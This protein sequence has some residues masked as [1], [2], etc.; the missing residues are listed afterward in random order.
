MSSKIN[1]FIGRNFDTEKFSGMIDRGELQRINVQFKVDAT[2][3]I[4]DIKAR[5]QFKPLEKEA[6]RVLKKLP[7]ITPGK[8]G[9]R[10]VAVIY[11]VPI[12]FKMGY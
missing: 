3:N 8:Q 1:K 9:D 4:T 7:L 6:I 2:G 10:K 5:S 12:V 11:N